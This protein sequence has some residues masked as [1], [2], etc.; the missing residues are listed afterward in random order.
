MLYLTGSAQFTPNG[1]Q[2]PDHV[3]Y[4]IQHN[5]ITYFIESDGITID[6]AD[7]LSSS[8]PLNLSQQG[9]SLLHHA[10]KI[11]WSNSKYKGE[12]INSTPSSG[13]YNYLVGPAENH[14]S[15][16]QLVKG[17]EMQ[18]VWPGV[19]IRF[20][21]TE[22]GLKYDYVIAN[23]GSLS[24]IR[25]E[26]VGANKVQL[27]K[28]DLHISTH[29]GTLIERIP[30]SWSS[31]NNEQTPIAIHYQLNGTEIHLS[32]K[33]GIDN[34]MIVDPTLQGAS[35]V[36][37]V[38]QFGGAAV[39]IGSD[40]TESGEVIGTSYISGTS[41]YP[42]T[43]GVYSSPFTNSIG[44]TKFNQDLTELVWS[45]ELGG[46]GRHSPLASLVE[47]ERIILLFQ[48]SCPEEDCIGALPQSAAP[49]CETNADESSTSFLQIAVLNS[50]ASEIL[51]SRV[52]GN[53]DSYVG[54]QLSQWGAIGRA[55][56]AKAA[57]GN[58]VITATAPN[59]NFPITEG[60]YDND[61]FSENELSRKDA[62]LF[63]I[64][65]D[66]ETLHWSTFYGGDKDEVGNSL[67]INDEG[68]IYLGGSTRFDS[69]PS[70][71]SEGAW[72]ST[73]TMAD[74][75]SGFIAAF[76][77]DGEFIA[78]TAVDFEDDLVN[79]NPKYSIGD[80][81]SVQFLELDPE[82][83]VWAYGYVKGNE[84]DIPVSEGVYFDTLGS[85]FICKFSPDLSELLLSTR[86]GFDYN[87]DYGPTAFMIDNCGYIYTSAQTATTGMITSANLSEDA[88][89]DS[90]GFYL[91]V[92]EPEMAGL[93]YATCFGGDHIDGS[94]SKFDK[95]GVVYQSVCVPPYESFFE[96]T[97]GAWS[98]TQLST[99]ELGVYKIDFE[100]QATTASFSYQ[101]EDN[102]NCPPFSI[103]VENYSTEGNYSWLL[104]GE[105]ITPEDGMIE[106]SEGGMHEIALA[107]FNEASCNQIDTLKKTFTLP[108]IPEPEALFVTEIAGLCDESLTVE[109]SSIAVNAPQVEWFWNNQLQDGADLLIETDEPGSY[110]LLLIA[111]DT[112]CFQQDS[113]TTIIDF[114][115][116][117]FNLETVVSDSC[118]LPVT[119]DGNVLSDEWNTI[120]W[121]VNNV[122]YSNDP[123]ISP[124]FEQ[125]QHSVELTVSNDFC[126]SESIEW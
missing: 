83:N 4:K 13:V 102:N 26:I 119:F 116:I 90:G 32:N 33:K 9:D 17:F 73:L 40:Y 74:G 108:L 25:L 86:V 49:L 110:E 101:L 120:Q 117:D 71:F 72:K 118:S 10:I 125:G 85:G 88:L 114:F 22:R 54:N 63:K 64:S 81:E 18:D 79:D 89:Q 3:L 35:Y 112:I 42:V 53:Y 34:S 60:A 28:E 103:V 107:V 27:L 52:I 47:D 95:K 122:F 1:G 82:G 94:H 61:N 39:G 55:D 70:P 111:T 37:A 80:S 123:T 46:L 106:V 66:L 104:D 11:K 96:P 48:T 8:H 124:E 6:V 76:S 69:S 51:Y 36:G 126:P 56:I 30:T 41:D 21:E 91:A 109:A 38:G 87:L 15:N 57:D 105:E 100:S 59:N 65:P 43:L 92:Y 19:N 84:S 7:P 45:T 99:Y 67:E 98:E 44:I 77:D 121:N 12:I 78:A 113:L 75:Y 50:A 14:V 23:H 93:H 31:I 24:S 29:C 16:L 62:V 68:T 97:A 58:Y 5:N 2:W 115:P 20:Q